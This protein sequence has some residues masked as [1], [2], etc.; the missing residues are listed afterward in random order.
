M[1]IGITLSF[2]PFL[3]S[4]NAYDDTYEFVSSLSYDDLPYACQQSEYH[5][6]DNDPNMW[7]ILGE[8][9]HLK[10][11]LT[12]HGDDSEDTYPFD[13]NLILIEEDTNDQ[14]CR[15]R[16]ECT[17]VELQSTLQ[18]C[19]TLKNACTLPC[20][21]SGNM[22]ITDN[23]DHDRR[24]VICNSPPLQIA[25]GKEE[26]PRE[27]FFLDTTPCTCCVSSI[28]DW[29]DVCQ[30]ETF[31]S[32]CG[33]I[34]CQCCIVSC[35]YE[36]K[37]WLDHNHRKYGFSTREILSVENAIAAYFNIHYTEPCV[38]MDVVDAVNTIITPL[39]WGDC[40]DLIL[41]DEKLEILS[42]FNTG[43]DQHNAPCPIL[44]R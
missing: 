19:Y 18:E 10:G 37:Q 36:W 6:I 2:C 34:V 11:I 35:G 39:L 26:H 25:L 29:S 24:D 44:T 32:P 23:M 31:E 27:C 3:V 40:H 5:L 20:G 14:S 15:C 30:N 8:E 41:D 9:G 16:R 12:A 7:K 33:I 21:N 17:Y 42:R 1:M 13:K 43:K 38:S 4:C 22:D 28:K